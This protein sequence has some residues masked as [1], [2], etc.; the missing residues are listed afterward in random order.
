MSIVGPSTDTVRQYL[1]SSAWD[2]SS[3]ISFS[4]LSVASQDST[5]NGIYI[6]PDSS[7]IYIVG[8]LN[9]SVYRYDTGWNLSSARFIYPST[10]YFSL[11]ANT[12]GPSGV[13][14]KPDGSRMY[15]TDDTND[16]LLDYFLS[17]AW[18]VS[19]ATIADSVSLTQTTD[20]FGIYF[21]ADG[22]KMY[23]VDLINA[24]VLEYNLP[25]A[26][27]IST[28]VFIGPFAVNVQEGN[29]TGIFFKPDGLEMY[30]TGGNSDSV[31]QYTLSTAW[32]IG[33][34]SF[35]QSFSLAAQETNPTSLFFKPDGLK[36]YV[37]GTSGD[38]VNEYD[39]SVAWDIST[40]VFVQNFS[41]LA[42]DATPR[43]LFFKPDGLKMYMA[44]DSVDAVWSYDLV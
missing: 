12:T 6:S 2:I 22:L 13:F 27:V 15:V 19:T 10:D 28:R 26:W 30:I 39:L 37:A 18:D 5:P 34:A 31:V 29:P 9:D 24:R 11:A 33:T 1:L 7:K 41:V 36:M 44:G 17:T 21:R 42:Q 32:N 20:P 4:A 23:V 14:F 43:G 40:S 35:T 38:D 16:G 25:T 3:A 8:A